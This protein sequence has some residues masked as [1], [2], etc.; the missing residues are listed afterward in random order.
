MSNELISDRYVIWQVLYTAEG[1][2]VYSQDVAMKYQ[3][4][5][6]LF[7]LSLVLSFL[8]PHSSVLLLN[9]FFVSTCRFV[10]QSHGVC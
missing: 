10:T 6:N 7:S 3:I 5:D 8:C 1:D 2:D 9:D 4:A